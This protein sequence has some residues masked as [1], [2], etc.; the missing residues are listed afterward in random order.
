MD[1]NNNAIS[2]NGTKLEVVGYGNMYMYF[3]KRYVCKNL[4]QSESSS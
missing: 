4:G 2:N 3:L 1:A